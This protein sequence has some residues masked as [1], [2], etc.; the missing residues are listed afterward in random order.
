MTTQEEVGPSARPRWR[1]SVRTRPHLLGELAIVAALLLVYD[2]VRSL[3]AVRPSVAVSHGWD[4][5]HAEAAMHLRIEGT[6]N[7]WLTEHGFVRVLAVDYYQFLHVTVAMAVLAVCYLRRPAV[8]R[9]VRNALVLTNLVGLAVF[10]F[11]PTAPPRLLPG[12][13]FVD[14]VARAGFGANH[15]SIHADQYGAIP[16]LHLAWATWVAIAGLAMARGRILRGLLV[17][18]PVL[19]AVVVV[20]TANH[21][22]FDVLTG[23]LLGAVAT[24]VCGVVPLRAQRVTAGSGARLDASSADRPLHASMPRLVRAATSEV[25]AAGLNSSTREDQVTRLRPDGGGRTP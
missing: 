2:R 17:A 20:A 18:Y 11:F 14:S 13:G 3:V 5:L 16:S 21:Y 6:L 1:T 23:T 22:V 4:I 15:G 7:S 10:A 25:G 9:P 12:A 19:T 24:W 8:Y